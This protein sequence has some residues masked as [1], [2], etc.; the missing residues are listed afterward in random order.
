MPWEKQFDQAEV[1][2]KA[3]RAFWA[4]GFDGT[5]MATLLDEM[6]IQKGS[7]YATFGSKQQV[8]L[9]ALERYVQGRFAGAGAMA[10][11]DSPL[12]ALQKHMHEIAQDAISDCGPLGCL[13]ANAAVEVAPKDADVKAFV[14]RTFE[15]HI[16][17]YRKVLDAAKSKGE[18]PASFDS[19]GV[20]RTLLALVLGI[21]VLSR[22]GLGRAVIHAVRDQAVGLI[23][24]KSGPNS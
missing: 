13:V 2:D 10:E 20:A 6:G 3:T 8:Y 24:G 14:H 19:L 9:E 17:V 12:S 21:R 5:P 7:F 11:A 4:G 16:A 22:A 1:L 18:L 23:S 15:M